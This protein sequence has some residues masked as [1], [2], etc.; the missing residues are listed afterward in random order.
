M[1]C[2]RAIV[3]RCRSTMTRHPR[4]R[5]QAV[6]RRSDA[7]RLQLQKIGRAISGLVDS[8]PSYV[9]REFGLG[10][11]A[12]SLGVVSVFA[13]YSTAH[14]GGPCSRER[15]VHAG[16]AVLRCHQP[17]RGADESI[18]LH[19]RRVGLCRNGLSP[20]DAQRRGRRHSHSRH[21]L[22][23]GLA[24]PASELN[25]RLPLARTAQITRGPWAA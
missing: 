6:D 25:R 2:P 9:P 12:E 5:R 24:W 13:R 22:R 16:R 18:R 8:G 15:A 3:K 19:C 7:S 1:T 4:L 10:G 21:H 14:T 17:T 20:A 11:A 23:R